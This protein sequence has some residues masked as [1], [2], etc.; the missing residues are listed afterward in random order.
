M[1]SN[2]SKALSIKSVENDVT[3]SVKA[4][5]NASRDQI[6]G[7]LGDALKIKTA[8]PPE[9]GKANKAI[10]KL[11]AKT[12]GVATRNVEI[13]QGQTQSNKTI[14]ITDITV[15]Q[16]HHVLTTYICE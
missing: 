12:I 10:I 1:I 5:P 2:M 13:T 15:D 7:L 3:F 14:R 16:L 11:I 9:S 4:I 6:V 8:A